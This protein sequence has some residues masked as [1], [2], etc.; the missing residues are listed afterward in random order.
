MKKQILAVAIAASLAVPQVG[1]AAEDDSGMQY[2][3]AS[4]GLFGSLRTRFNT[5]DTK[6]AN[7]KIEAD[8]SVFG[9]R[10][11]LDL[12]N[13]LTGIYH[14]EQRIL[15]HDGEGVGQDDL[16]GSNDSGGDARF[17][18]VGVRG[19]FGEVN[20]GSHGA[21]V[22]G[23]PN[24]TDV[25][26]NGGGNFVPFYRRG[27]SFQYVS[28]ELNGFQAGGHFR[29]TGGTDAVTAGKDSTLMCSTGAA[30][31]VAVTGSATE[32]PEAT[33][34]KVS[35]DP[36]TKASPG[37]PK[38]DQWAIGATYKVRGF[39]VGGTYMVDPEEWHTTA[40]NAAGDEDNAGMNSRVFKQEDMTQWFV[41]GKYKQDN[42]MVAVMH[43]QKNTSDAP[44]R[45]EFRKADTATGD[46]GY[47]VGSTKGEDETYTSIGGSITVGKVGLAAL[48]DIR[49]DT[50]GQKG[51]DKTVTAFSA[52][53]NFTS[54]ARV[55]AAYIA[56]DDETV[57]NEKD[58]I[59]I[60][61][62]M[63]F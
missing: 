20:F 1:F 27:R 6:N 16:D 2:T 39:Q 21:F 15:A 23:V 3:S 12:G 38:V 57:N 29:M 40:S 9:Y 17:N 43:G 28:P 44:E 46:A 22:A 61:M 11:S 51:M 42:W 32:C 33:A 49:S 35:G 41:S 48:H 45:F 60:G 14:Y 52:T 8:G 4:E 13:G 50:D 53:Y 5:G 18:F 34:V 59:T 54:R 63:D 56:N 19:A 55:W 30:A 37:A 58:Q 26:A 31:A 10:G 36:A 47:T 24:V 25:T 7:T 62:R